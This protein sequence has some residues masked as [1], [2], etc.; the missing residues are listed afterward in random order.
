MCSHLNTGAAETGVNTRCERGLKHDSVSAGVRTVVCPMEQ[1]KDPPPVRII[2]ITFQPVNSC[3][4]TTLDH[5]EMVTKLLTIQIKCCITAVV[6]D[7]TCV[8]MCV[9]VQPSDGP[10]DLTTN[11]QLVP[12][13]PGGQY[14]SVLSVCLYHDRESLQI[15]NQLN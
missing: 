2:P 3:S 9:C 10:L 6:C 11:G 7:S 15:P 8:C 5:T 4:P 1:Q 12:L 13:L 14:S